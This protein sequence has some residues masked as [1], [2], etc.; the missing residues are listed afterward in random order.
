[1]TG[2]KLIRKDGP[3]HIYQ[4]QKTGRKKVF[5]VNND[6]SKTDGSFKKMC[7]AKEIVNKF[8][9][10]GLVTHVAKK[11][12]TYADVSQVPD[13]HQSMTVIKE[14][15]SEFMQLPAKIRK[16][17]DNDMTK[18]YNFIM[19][20]NNDEEAVKLGLKSYSKEAEEQLKAEAERQQEARNARSTKQSS[21]STNSNSKSNKV[22]QK[23]ID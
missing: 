14:A 19:D 16:K 1:M 6:V 17:F 12:G 20:P 7:D 10:T 4:C 15:E 18:Y 3:K 5:T 8:R 2:F 23:D 9:T 22:S 13:L 21:N 11:Q